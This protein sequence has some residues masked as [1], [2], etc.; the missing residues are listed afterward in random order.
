MTRPLS[1]TELQDFII[2]IK[3]KEVSFNL[4]LK[5]MSNVVIDDEKECWL[6]G[7]DWSS[8]S[9]VE[10]I[11]AHRL[12]YWIFTGEKPPHNLEI[13][14][15]CDRKGCINPNHLFKGTHSDNF[16]ML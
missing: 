1:K 13:C 4:F 9:K 12:S 14:H 15:N 11:Q 6:R 16:R 7:K 2:R 10:N 8:Y 3:A 5:L